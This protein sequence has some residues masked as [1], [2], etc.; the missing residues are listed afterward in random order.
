[1]TVLKDESI[2]KEFGKA[3]KQLD[4]KNMDA[5]LKLKPAKPRVFTIYDDYGVGRLGDALK[6]IVFENKDVNTALK[7]AEELMNQDIENNKN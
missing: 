2:R 1:M 3:I 5:V 4:N 7:E 6:S